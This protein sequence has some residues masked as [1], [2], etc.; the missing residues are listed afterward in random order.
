M[1]DLTKEEIDNLHAEEISEE[2]KKLVKQAVLERNIGIIEETIRRLS[3]MRE[4]YEI[5]KWSEQ[6]AKKKEKN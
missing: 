1:K 6:E 4:L 2:I 5:A 3:F